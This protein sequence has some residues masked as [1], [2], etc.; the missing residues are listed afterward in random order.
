MADN[1]NASNFAKIM[2]DLKKGDASQSD[3]LTSQKN[4][5]NAVNNI[6]L[7]YQQVNGTQ[8]KGNISGTDPVL[9]KGSSARLSTVSVISA[10]STVGYVYDS[11]TTTITAATTKLYV[12]PMTVGAYFINMP[13]SLGLVIVPGTGQ[14]VTVS[15]A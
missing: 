6:A 5:V 14:V 13:A 7:T 4:L 1:L 2:T 12:I 9:V 10:G 3:L 15:Y 8:I 11:K